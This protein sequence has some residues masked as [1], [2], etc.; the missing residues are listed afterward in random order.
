MPDDT[1]STS[2]G[3]PGEH[4]RDLH[5]LH[6]DDALPES[7]GKY[8]ILKL[9]GEGGMGRVYLAWHPQLGAEVALKV[10][11][12]P[13]ATPEFL[14]RL[15]REV[16]AMSEV[17]HDHVVRV[18]DAD[19]WTSPHGPRAYYVMESLKPPYVLN[20][21]TL[22]SGLRLDR[23]VQLLNDAARGL[24]AAHTR[25]IIHADIKPLNILV[26]A[27][28]GR[29][30]PKV[31]DFGLA[32]MMSAWEGKPLSAGG[33]WAYLAPELQ[34]RGGRDPDARSDV[35]AFGITMHE[36][37][38]GARPHAGHASQ[39]LSAFPGQL[40]RIVRAA[41]APAPKDRYASA[42]EV[43]DALLALRSSWSWRL[44]A[45]ADRARSSTI[46]ILAGIVA[47][48][49][50]LLGPPA[51][52][53]W[54]NVGGWLDRV[55]DVQPLPP[56]RFDHVCVVA[57]TDDSR[58]RAALADSAIE[59]SSRDGNRLVHARLLRQLAKVAPHAVVLDSFFA[60]D[61]PADAELVDAMSSIADPTDGRTPRPVIQGWMSFNDP[62]PLG[63]SMCPLIKEQRWF[64]FAPAAVADLTPGTFAVALARLRPGQHDPV[65]GMAIMAA[66]S[67]LGDP[68]S[69]YQ[70]RLND[71]KNSF[72][73]V[74]YKDR[75][76]RDPAVGE[77]KY[78]PVPAWG[79][80]RGPD[81][82]EGFSMG[83]RIALIP[84]A[85]PP[86][87]A[88]ND[89]SFTI[90][91]ATVLSAG[92]DDLSKLITGKIVILADFRPLKDKMIPVSPS[93]SVRGAYVQAVAIQQLVSIGAT[94]PAV[95]GPW[96]RFLLTFASAWLLLALATSRL[97]WIR[98]VR[99]LPRLALSVFVS[100]G[101]VFLFLAC[102]LH[103]A[104]YDCNPAVP[105]LAVL[106]A[107]ACFL[108]IHR[109]LGWPN[110]LETQA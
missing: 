49:A 15:S 94:M 23:R 57:L 45:L 90:D 58:T 69:F 77:T 36:V 55:V 32:R 89:P 7:I 12:R 40:Q 19:I 43:A 3:D 68:H 52:F 28:E 54:T 21:R 34:E 100:C 107:A 91:A 4:G 6:A 31:A 33:T 22:L 41:M 103:F 13:P 63:E 85:I 39:A 96:G 110:S 80:F 2:P 48:A 97:A 37:L 73:L 59:P 46:A 30:I 27:R 74:P 64:R 14:S 66:A 20:D 83:D 1:R 9:L 82:R 10:V 75:D 92:P 79:V 65:P 51:L 84:P 17:R 71:R 16:Q 81:S 86:D 25:G 95:A 50:I 101:L 62:S 56:S 108:L 53:Q 72:V 18:Y 70:V 8:K 44:R 104:R 61:S 93:R 102:L 29:L 60:G 76:F 106:L 98:R 88:L 47:V 67:L 35:Y 11:L 42:G 26:E 38:T 99:L 87:D 109:V 5:D 78:I 105:L 24:A